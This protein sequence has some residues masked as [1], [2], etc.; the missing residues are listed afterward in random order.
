MQNVA[1][2]M[3]FTRPR[4]DHV[5]LPLIVQSLVFGLDLLQKDTHEKECWC[6][7]TN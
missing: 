4:D 7:H 2:Y 5:K 6:F 1:T 3:N